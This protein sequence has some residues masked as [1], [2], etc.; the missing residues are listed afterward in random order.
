[1]NIK[2]ASLLVITSL[3]ATSATFAAWSKKTENTGNLGRTSIIIA[4]GAEYNSSKVSLFGA[5]ER[6][7]AVGASGTLAFNIPVFKPSVNVLKDCKWFGM[8]AQVFANGGYSGETTF[9]NPALSSVKLSE[10]RFDIGVGLTPYLNF[11]TSLEYLKAVK[12]FVLVAA[13]YSIASGSNEAGGV[14][15]PGD[16]FLSS[17]N[18]FFYKF[19]GG[20]EFVITDKLSVTPTWIW[21][22]NEGSNIACTQAVGLDLTY[23]ATDQLGVSFFWTHDFGAN[24][25]ENYLGIDYSK[26]TRSDVFGLK[27]RIGFAR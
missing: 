24:E 25:S 12:P 22:G 19:G 23:W 5:S 13:G 21:N 27:L 4:A 18:Y 20:V 8:D 10:V 7:D 3:L 26:E 1:M 17:P 16:G 15:N 9:T 11:E 14:A 2:K 6:S